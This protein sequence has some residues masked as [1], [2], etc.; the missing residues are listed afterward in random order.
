[1][2]ATR[3]WRENHQTQKLCLMIR[4]QMMSVSQYDSDETD[5]NDSDGNEYVSC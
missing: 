4:I 2:D 5:T 3:A 1:M